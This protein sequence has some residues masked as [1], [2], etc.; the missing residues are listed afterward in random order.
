[1]GY[2]TVFVIECKRLP[3]P[4]ND[5]KKEYIIGNLGGIQRF[6]ELHHGEDFSIAGMIAYIEENTY[7]HWHSMINSWI[8]ELS[9]ESDSIWTVEDKLK[10]EYQKQNIAKYK[11]DHTNI[12]L[13]HFW[14]RKEPNQFQE[15]TY[16]NK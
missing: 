6:K 8:D 1:M 2:K 3:A 14:L 4:S 11:S 7:S 13:I 15:V 10:I 5:R 12:T 9:Q 16:G